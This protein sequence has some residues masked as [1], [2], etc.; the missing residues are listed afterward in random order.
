MAA[1]LPYLLIAVEE[2]DLQKVTISDMQILKTV[3]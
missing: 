2:I 3:S 1:S